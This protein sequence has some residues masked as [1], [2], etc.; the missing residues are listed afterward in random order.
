[1]EWNGMESKTLFTHGD[2]KI[3]RLQNNALL[4]FT[5][6]VQIITT[7]C[8][9]IYIQ[10]YINILNKRIIQVECI[11]RLRDSNLCLKALINFSYFISSGNAIPIFAPV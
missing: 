4:F 2:F 6:A 1:M 5:K 9:K 3:K 7:N 8:F 10:V 11:E